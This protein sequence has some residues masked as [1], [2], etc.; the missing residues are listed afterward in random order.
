MRKQYVVKS[1]LIALGLCSALGAGWGLTSVQAQPGAGV[2]KAGKKGGAKKGRAKL[3]K[4]LAQ[5]ETMTGPLTDAQRD[6]ITTAI[7]D[8]DAAMEKARND[9]IA[10]LSKTTKM[11]PEEVSQKLKEARKANAPKKAAAAG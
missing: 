2:P 11:T 1:T 6:E 7:K 9:Y 4:E 10:A 8:R 3:L 5:I